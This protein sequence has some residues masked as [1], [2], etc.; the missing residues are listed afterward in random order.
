MTVRPSPVCRSTGSPLGDQPRNRLVM[1]RYSWAQA[2]EVSGSWW[3]PWTAWLKPFA[4][5]LVAARAKLGDAKHKP[6]ESAPGRYVAERA[7]IKK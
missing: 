1:V 4:G 7:E 2:K 6:L 5:K 3:V